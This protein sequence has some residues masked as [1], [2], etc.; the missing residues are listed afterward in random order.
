MRKQ[1]LVDMVESRV[2][3]GDTPADVKSSIHGAIIEKH[4]EAVYNELIQ[5]SYLAVRF[6]CTGQL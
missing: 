2:S 5:Q 3:G 6:V 1:E 4:L